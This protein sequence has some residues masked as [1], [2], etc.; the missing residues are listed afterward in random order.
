[1]LKLP[2]DK[3]A[4]TISPAA[5]DRTEFRR[6]VKST[7]GGHTQGI[8]IERSM[9]MAQNEA[10]KTALEIIEVIYDELSK[11]KRGGTDGRKKEREN[12]GANNS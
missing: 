9:S 4:Q 12:E 11:E 6:I 1:M 3:I 10:R 7:N 8:D 2:V 5:F